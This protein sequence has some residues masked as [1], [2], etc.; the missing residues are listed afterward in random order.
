MSN[1]SNVGTPARAE[2]HCAHLAVF[3]GRFQP[4]HNGHLSVVTSALRTADTLV[5]LVGS[6]GQPRGYFNPFTFEE[7]KEMI[8]ASLPEN[9]RQRVLVLPLLDW[10]YNNTRW[11]QGVQDAVKSALKHFDL[12]HWAKVALIGHSK[13][14]SSF[15][16]KMFPQW[17]EIEV[18]NFQG[19]SATPMREKLFNAGALF[20]LLSHVLPDT[21]EPVQEIVFEFSKTTAFGE[22]IAEYEYIENYKKPYAALPYPPIF[23]TVD[24]CVVQSGHI[25]L[26][27]RR[28]NPG[29]D[30]WALPGGFV[31]ADEHIEDA[32]YRELREET[33][34]KVPE[35][36][37]RGCTIYNRRF[38]NPHRSARGRVITDAFLIK[39]PDDTA[40]P[41]VR[42]SD[43]AKKAK[44][45]ALDDVTRDM[46]FEDHF[47][48]IE[49]LKAKLDD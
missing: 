7:R 40:L 47:H 48:M 12:D 22:M 27:Q 41:K 39:L 1:L 29:K 24:A 25:L 36:A 46:M 28:S 13:D 2:Y 38:D 21:P 17:A 33:R 45:W 16:L 35:K 23:Q 9:Q 6:A 4:F 3:I 20:E 44:W 26:I 15:Y 8:L 14:R 31:N 42:G 32:V 11:V 49:N 18:P 19:L 10:T 34:L 30:L 43:D 37:L 5:I